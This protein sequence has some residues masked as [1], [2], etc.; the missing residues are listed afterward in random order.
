MAAISTILLGGA[1]AFS[2]GSTAYSTSDAIRTRAM[3][4][5]VRWD[6]TDLFVSRQTATLEPHVLSVLNRV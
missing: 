2:A 5:T 4:V 3:K 1:L 6:E